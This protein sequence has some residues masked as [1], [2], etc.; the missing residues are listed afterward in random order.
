MSQ[1]KKRNGQLVEFD[2]AKVIAAANKAFVE[3][4]VEMDDSVKNRLLLAVAK[5]QMKDIVDIEDIQDTVEDVL[6][7]TG[8]KQ[9]AK[10]Y[11]V[12]RYQRKLVRENT[13]DETLIEY[14]NGTNEYWMRENANK[15]A[16]RTSCQRDKVAGITST[17]FA[18]R[19]LLPKDVLE[20]HDKGIIHLHDI[21]YMIHPGETNCCLINGLDMLENGTK[22]N[23]VRIDPP[24]RFSTACTIATQIQLQVSGSQYGGMTW[25]CAH[26]APS[27]RRTY[28]Y[29][30]ALGFEGEDLE[31]LVNDNIKEGVQ[32]YNYQLNSFT[33]TSG[34]SPF[35]TL[36]IDLEELPGY[37]L[38]T[39]RIAM[40]FLRQ[41]IKGFKNADGVWVTPTFPKIIVVLRDKYFTE[42]KYKD[43]IQLCAECTAK[44]MVPDYMS[45]K[46]M[47]K[48]KGAVVPAMGC[49][50]LLKPIY[51]DGKL[52]LYGRFNL[53]V[54]TV[55]LPYAA[56]V[57]KKEGRDF[58]EVLDGYLALCRKAQLTR[59]KRIANS[60]TDCAPILWQD[61]A[62]MRA[63]AGE[64]LEKYIYGGYASISLGY[65]GVYEA[66]MI[67]TNES[68]SGPNGGPFAEKVM[69]YLDDTTQKW[70]KEDNLG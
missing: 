28:D 66:T 40:E 60:T 53:G 17:D 49:R 10:A 45:E 55:N 6:M 26:F 9:V 5:L 57:A 1:V 70:A 31:K 30:E 42:P 44:R 59:V 20:A 68:Q 34:Q 39:M 58:F 67:M 2:T 16:E 13:T 63:P 14:L 21:D 69:K 11:I 25:S 61:G 50:S 52:K 12:Y 54:C 36:H 43:F 64:K 15:K 56:Y 37:E 65:A 8:Y 47:L 19:L 29:Y 51:P 62:F 4:N 41:R 7:K 46:N 48:Y 27:L 3:C 35:S 32:T 24:R 22:L 33:S 23:D 18:R 38:D